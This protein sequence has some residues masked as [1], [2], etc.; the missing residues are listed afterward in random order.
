LLVATRSTQLTPS[1]NTYQWFEGHQT[2]A[3]I[4]NARGFV[5]V[6]Q[7]RT[8]LPVFRRSYV[9]ESVNP[10]SAGPSTSPSMFPGQGQRLDG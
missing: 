2:L 4:V 5:S 6:H 7:D 8:F 1:T 3:P 9:D 10:S